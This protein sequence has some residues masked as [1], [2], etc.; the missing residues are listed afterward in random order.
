M[1][2][3]W[4]RLNGPWPVR[5]WFTSCWHEGNPSVCTEGIRK[6][7]EGVGR[8]RRLWMHL[9]DSVEG[10]LPGDR[11]WSIVEHKEALLTQISATAK[12]LASQGKTCLGLIIGNHEEAASKLVGC[13]SEKISTDAGVPN[14]GQ[15]HI[16]RVACAS[17]DFVMY[18]AHPRLM[19]GGYAGESERLQQNQQINLRNRLKMFRADLHIIGHTHRPIVTP[20]VTVPRMMLDAHGE[21][22]YAPCLMDLDKSWYVSVQAM[23]RVYDEGLRN[24][25][26]ANALRPTTLGWMG[27]VIEKDGRISAIEQYNEHGKIER[28]HEPVQLSVG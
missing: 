21:R 1:K 27:T 2:N 13:V 19:F 3:P 4:I 9:G 7:L 11:R 16:A 23:F 26:Q 25:A 17:G 12:R 20:P 8:H 15:T 22:R 18:A 14:L 10:V 5:I 28:T 24:Y 6:F